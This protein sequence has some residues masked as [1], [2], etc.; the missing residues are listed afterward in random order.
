MSEEFKIDTVPDLTKRITEQWRAKEKEA[1]A[2]Q[3]KQRK[4]LKAQVELES[5][6]Q[7]HLDNVR[8]VASNL[9]KEY[10]RIEVEV[11]AEK[12]K[13]ATKGVAREADIRSGKITLREFLSKG[14]KDSAISDEVMKKSAGELEAGLKAIRSKNLEVLKLEKSLCECQNMI[15]NLIL[16]PAMILQQVLK[17]CREIT[18]QEIGLFL[19]DNYGN[20]QAVEQIKHKLLLTEGKSLTPG[21]RWD[22]LTIEEAR[23]VQFDPILPLSLVEKLK[24]EL[25]RFKDAE[26]V[27]IAYYLRTKDLDV[28]S[29]TL[30]KRKIVT[31]GDEPFTFEKEGKHEQKTKEKD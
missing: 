12:R 27:N 4:D 16:R 31:T 30:P 19:D 9:E 10:S 8:I 6:I 28:T 21:Y 15:R 7:T 14:K 17:D 24:S 20:R 29:F 23:K 18:D 11:I 3:K 1:L 22:S 2:L 13:E 26:T 5:T 25:K